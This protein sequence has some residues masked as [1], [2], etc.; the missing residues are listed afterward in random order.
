MYYWCIADVLIE[1]LTDVLM[2]GEPIPVVS[3][4]EYSVFSTWSY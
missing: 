4:P 1:I 3:I 2:Y